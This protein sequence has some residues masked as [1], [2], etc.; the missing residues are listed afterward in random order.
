[1]STRD[2]NLYKSFQEWF[3][4]N[5]DVET[6]RNLRDHGARCG[7]DGL[8]H[9]SETVALFNAFK[10]EIVAR[11]THIDET[12]IWE[13]A[14]R[15]DALGTTQQINALVWTAAEGIA[16]G[17]GDYLDELKEEEERCAKALISVEG[18]NHE[19]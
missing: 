1:M 19:I 15:C 3:F 2:V 10:N 18:G 6:A 12:D 16:H 11:A 7:I 4:E 14:K 17:Y 13:I 8:R 9:Y 5:I